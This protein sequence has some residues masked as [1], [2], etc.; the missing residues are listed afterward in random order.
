VAGNA[1]G[2]L[3]TSTNPGAASS[4]QEADSG[5]SVQ[6]T[7]V[8]CV[9]SRQCIAV[10]NNG[11]VITST[12]PTAGGP[13]SLTKLIPFVQTAN[14]LDG[15]LNALFGTSCASGS[16]CALVGADGQIFTSTNPFA[17][18]SA[19]AKNSGKGKRR[20]GPK[21][22]KITIAKLILPAARELLDHGR[23]RVTVRFYA[24]GPVRRVECE[25]NHRRLHPC[26]SPERFQVGK[27]GT[28]SIRIRAVGITGLRGPVAVKRFWTG[29]RCTHHQCFTPDGELPLRRR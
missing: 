13:W 4:W 12:D 3:L 9:P 24:N 7:S 27:K 11:D 6:V 29:K 16:F 19:P 28:Y 10:D 26:R 17:A 8:T 14:E 18:P 15:P 20:H 25:V 23:G 21:R 5:V 2:N 1:G 22:P